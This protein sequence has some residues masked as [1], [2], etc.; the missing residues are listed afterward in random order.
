[1]AVLF[2][3]SFISYNMQL[4]HHVKKCAKRGVEGVYIGVF[5]ANSNWFVTPFVALGTNYTRENKNEA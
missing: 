3:I 2:E 1:M 5:Q 4:Q